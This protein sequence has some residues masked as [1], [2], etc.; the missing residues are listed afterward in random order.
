MLKHCRFSL[1][2]RSLFSYLHNFFVSNLAGAY[3]CV[4]EPKQRKKSGVLSMSHLHVLV[5][6]SVGVRR[7][8]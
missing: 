8:N 7:R 3:L 2:F 5:N 1:P 6:A 4:S